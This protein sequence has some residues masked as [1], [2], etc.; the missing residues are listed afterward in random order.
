MVQDT[1]SNEVITS[2]PEQFLREFESEVLGRVPQE[3]I[4]AGLRQAKLARIMKQAGS[5]YIPGVGQ[6]IA[7]IDARLYFRMMQSFGHEE[8]WLKDMLADNPE[9]CA[10]GYRPK[11]NGLRHSKTFVN[12]KPV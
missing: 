7:E 8:N 10:P 6:K 9:L 11:N 1:D 2:L 5:S 4:E 12:G 3:K